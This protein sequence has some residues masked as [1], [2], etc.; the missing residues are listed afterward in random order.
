MILTLIATR[1]NEDEKII[2]V[3][4]EDKKVYVIVK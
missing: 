3:T 2:T 1:D 4:Y